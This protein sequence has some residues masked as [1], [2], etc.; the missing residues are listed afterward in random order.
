MLVLFNFVFIYTQSSFKYKKA[1]KGSRLLQGS[2]MLPPP[3]PPPGL[4]PTPTSIQPDSTSSETD[5]NYGLVSDKAKTALPPPPPPPISNRPP[6]VHAVPPGIPQFP[7]PPPPLMVA[8]I[9]NRPLPPPPPLPPGV[10]LLQIPRPLFAGPAG[11]PGP[12]PGP[13]P[14]VGP[15]IMFGLP[16]PQDDDFTAFRPPV[17][18]K[19][20]Y[21]KSAAATVV[22]RPLAQHTPELTAMVCSWFYGCV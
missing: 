8:G 17:P 5:P 4:P 16:G 15:P 18:Q 21:V 1:L 7:P 12:P 9:P 14:L 11:P 10:A 3:P 20:S 13:P 6:L 22:K 2:A 19:P